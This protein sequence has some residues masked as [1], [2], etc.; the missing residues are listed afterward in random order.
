MN[1]KVKIMLQGWNAEGYNI[2]EGK[3][4]MP[5]AVRWMLASKRTETGIRAHTRVRMPKA[6]RWMHTHFAE[7]NHKILRRCA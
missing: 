4:R 2:R 7:Q 6:V 5:K 1:I 3:V